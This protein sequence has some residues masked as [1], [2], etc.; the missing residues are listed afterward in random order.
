MNQVGAAKPLSQRGS[1]RG[2]V[3]L[4]AAE[5]GLASAGAG[6]DKPPGVCKAEV[7]EIHF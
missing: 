7:I 6:P 2:G 4:F 1:M 5:S 3:L